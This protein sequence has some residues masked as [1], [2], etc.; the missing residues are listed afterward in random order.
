MSIANLKEAVDDADGHEE[1]LLMQFELSLHL[2]EPDDGDRSHVTAH[3]LTV[4][5]TRP[6]GRLNL[7]KHAFKQD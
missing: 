5:I 2:H 3:L 4:Q 7:E 6:D 1:G